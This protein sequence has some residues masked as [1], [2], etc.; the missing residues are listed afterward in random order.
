L[1]AP[2]TKELNQDFRLFLLRGSLSADGPGKIG[3]SNVVPGCGFI[4]SQSPGNRKLRRTRSASTAGSYGIVESIPHL[5]GPGLPK[6]PN[7]QLFEFSRRV[8]SP[9]AL[10]HFLSGAAH[11]GLNPYL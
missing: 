4:P 11:T 8:N 7:H 9:D 10:F 1:Y 6:R 5:K 2:R 3:F